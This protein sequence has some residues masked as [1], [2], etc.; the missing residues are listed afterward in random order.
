[1]RIP[2]VVHSFCVAMYFRDASAL[3]CSLHIVYLVSMVSQQ[4]VCTGI[5][6]DQVLP[7]RCILL[8]FFIKR[9]NFGT[10]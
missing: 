5:T 4:K 9:T 7:L 8:H 6:G 10:G 1:M 2:I 3:A